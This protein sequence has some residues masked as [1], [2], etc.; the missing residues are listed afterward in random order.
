[1][2]GLC[3]FCGKFALKKSFYNTMKF[4][5]LHINQNAG[6]QILECLHYKR[7]FSVLCVQFLAS[8]RRTAE[9]VPA[10]ERLWRL[11]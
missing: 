6:S 2:N 1:M 10:D 7:V 3:L 11:T 8:M 9:S 4:F 5:S